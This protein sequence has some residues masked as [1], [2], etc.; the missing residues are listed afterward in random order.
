MRTWWLMGEDKDYRLRRIS[1]G[2]QD[3]P[4]YLPPS[5][6]AYLHHSATSPAQLETPKD[7]KKILNLA[8]QCTAL[9]VRTLRMS[10]N[11]PMLSIHR[12]PGK[13]DH[14]RVF[15]PFSGSF[16]YCPF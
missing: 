5:G 4:Q 13:Y 15:L 8:K 11:R 1:V 10:K 14:I 12:S 3:K 16:K 6:G 9:D 2:Q 7:N